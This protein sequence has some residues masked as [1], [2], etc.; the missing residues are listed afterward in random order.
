MRDFEGVTGPRGG[1]ALTVDEAVGLAP[2]SINAARL[3][4]GWRRHFKAKNSQRVAVVLDLPSG[5]QIAA[6]RLPLSYL[7]KAGHVPDR[8][9]SAVQKQIALLTGGDP[10]ASV[11][12]VAADYAQDPDAANA[13]W[14]DVLDFI[15]MHCVVLPKFVADAEADPDHPTT[16]TF[17]ISSVGELDKIY[18]Y[19]WCQGVNE[20]VETF[21]RATSQALGIVADGY[22][23]S[24]SAEQLLRPDQPGG[25]LAGLPD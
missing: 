5:E 20:T 14:F 10:Q 4:E 23:V 6:V 24:L 8:M 25:Y 11:E 13:E 17:P 9:S 21:L 12:A 16:P 3:N 1:E 15:W 18:L 7:L 22:N 2:V 19:E